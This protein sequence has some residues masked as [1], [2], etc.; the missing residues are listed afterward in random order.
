MRIMKRWLPGGAEGLFQE[1]S[2]YLRGVDGDPDQQVAAG[3]RA[4]HGRVHAGPQIAI[5]AP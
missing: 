5:P 2:D 4:G 3:L 1:M